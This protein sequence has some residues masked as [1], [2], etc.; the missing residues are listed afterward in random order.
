VRNNFKFYYKLTPYLAGLIK[1]NGLFVHDKNTKAKKY[2]PKI[3]IL[4][5]LADKSLAENYL[6][7]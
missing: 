6:F 3:I 2:R 5:N 7:Y 1:R 4:F